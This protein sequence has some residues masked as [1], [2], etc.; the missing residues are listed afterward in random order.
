M[1]QFKFNNKETYL[2]YRSAWKA[3]YAKL[4]QTIREKRWYNKEYQRAQNKAR[5][6]TSKGDC[7]YGRLWKN[8]EA[9][10]KDN[11]RFQELRLKYKEDRKWVELYSKEATAML[12]ELAEAKQEAQRQYLASK[13]KE[14]V[15][16]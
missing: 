15:M 3:E 14:L 2:A 8:T 9:L 5:P 13:E 16:A 6:L 4:S 1:T 12:A 10:L 11:V 7:Y